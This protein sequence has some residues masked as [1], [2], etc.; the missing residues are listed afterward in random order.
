VNS[1]LQP[2]GHGNVPLANLVASSFSTQKPSLRYSRCTEKRCSSS[3]SGGAFQSL[4]D[5]FS[6]VLFARSC[7]KD[8]LCEDDPACAAFLGAVAVLY[9]DGPACATILGAVAVFA[10]QSELVHY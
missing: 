3:V 6:E 9:E 4:L 5:S 8:V 1:R 10:V 2:Y 7:V